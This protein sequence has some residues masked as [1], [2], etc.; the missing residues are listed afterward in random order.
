MRSICLRLHRHRNDSLAS[1]VDI[2]WFSTVQKQSD[3][4]TEPL[5]LAHALIK[6]RKLQKAI[7]KVHLF[8]YGLL[9]QLSSW[10]HLDYLPS[11]HLHPNTK[12]G[13]SFPKPLYTHLEPNPLTHLSMPKSTDTC[14]TSPPPSS[15]SPPAPPHLHHKHLQ[16]SPLSSA[17]ACNAQPL[18]PSSYT[19]AR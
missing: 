9:F 10:R 8:P 11:L 5:N 17:P 14:Y 12:D 18:L 3:S 1:E 13:T 7:L 2:W 19:L 4:V 6:Q 16:A 15:S